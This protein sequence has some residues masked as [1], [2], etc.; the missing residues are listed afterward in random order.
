M[1]HRPLKFVMEATGA[2]LAQGDPSARIER[3]VVDSRTARPGDLFVALEGERFD[4]H[5]FVEAAARSGVTA[6]L[7]RSGKTAARRGGVRGARGGR[8]ATS[9]RPAGGALPG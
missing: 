1:D 7:V 6:V 9:P 4:G 2:E 8:H 3:V 5:D